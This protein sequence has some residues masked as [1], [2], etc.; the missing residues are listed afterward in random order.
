MDYGVDLSS[1]IP[2][3]NSPCFVNSQ[4]VFLLLVGILNWEEGDFNHCKSTKTWWGAPATYIF[5]VQKSEYQ[6]K[7]SDFSAF[8]A[9]YKHKAILEFVKRQILSKINTYGLG[10]RNIQN[11]HEI[12]S[13]VTRENVVLFLIN[14]ACMLLIQL[15]V[16]QK[17]QVVRGL[18]PRAILIL[19]EK[20]IWCVINSKLNSKPYDYNT[21]PCM[22]SQNFYFCQD[23]QRLSRVWHI[24]YY[25]YYI[26]LGYLV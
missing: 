3:T 20:L 23:Y 2:G 11:L 6:C 1:V 17:A 19:S 18:W 16:F 8:Y 21:M 26:L 10:L 24:V 12:L 13:M 4:L 15:C 5:L 14:F 22:P 9:V 7:L 25:I